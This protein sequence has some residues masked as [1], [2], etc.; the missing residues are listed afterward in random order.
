M[1]MLLFQFLHYPTFYK[2]LSLD[3]IS[4]RLTKREQYMILNLFLIKRNFEKN[5]FNLQEFLKCIRK[6]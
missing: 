4:K 2:K 6:L 5:E 1:M 3:S